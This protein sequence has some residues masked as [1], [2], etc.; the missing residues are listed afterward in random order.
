MGKSCC[1]VLVKV[2]YEQIFVVL[3]LDRGKYAR[4]FAKLD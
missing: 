2:A 1:H 3:V 4:D